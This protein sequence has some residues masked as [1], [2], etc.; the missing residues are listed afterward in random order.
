MGISLQRSVALV[1][2]LA[3]LHNFC[4]DE[5]VPSMTAADD[6]QLSLDG[7]VPLERSNAAQ[8]RLPRQLMDG[9]DHFEDMD[10]LT[11]RQRERDACH[12]SDCAFKSKTEILYALLLMEEIIRTCTISTIFIYRLH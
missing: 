6:L 10:R 11:R 8:M 2:A 1:V 5:T 3:K 9:G 4:I 12:V 7:G